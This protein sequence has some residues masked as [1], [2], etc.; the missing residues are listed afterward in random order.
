MARHVR[1]FRAPRSDVVIRRFLA[2]MSVFGIAH[3][4]GV[5]EVCIEQIIRRA[6]DKPAARRR[7]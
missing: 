4:Y 5:A 7:G 2:G 1:V 3:R 6:M